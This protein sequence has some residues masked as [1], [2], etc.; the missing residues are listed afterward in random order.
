MNDNFEICEEC[1]NQRPV[2]TPGCP[3]CISRVA[4]AEGHYGYFD[5]LNGWTCY[6]SCPVCNPSFS[7]EE[8]EWLNATCEDGNHPYATF[9]CPSC[10]HEVCWNCSVR[11]TDDSSGEGVFTCPSCGHVNHYPEVKE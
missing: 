8:G 2:N 5:L 3:T 11:C 4:D 10:R 1:D 9:N 6:R 7:E